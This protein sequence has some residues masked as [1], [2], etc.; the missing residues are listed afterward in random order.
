MRD[1]QELLGW[2]R[3]GRSVL[4]VWS[5]LL[6]LLAALG[7]G[8]V[9]AW[10][11]GEGP[12]YRTLFTAHSEFNGDVKVVEDAFTRF[13]MFGN[14][15][16]TGQD[17]KNLNRSAFRYV[18]GFHLG[19]A[20]VP[21][22]RSALFIGL[23]GGMG[24]RQFHDFY[25][26]MRIEAVEI[27]PLVV[28]LA[29]EYFRLPEDNRLKVFVGDGRAF[30]E[31]SKA[32]YDLIFLDAYDA[33]SAPPMLTTVEF[34]KIIRDHL[35][36]KGALVANVIAAERGAR[37]RFGRSEFKTFR[38]VFS[39]VAVFPIQSAVEENA[40]P[41]DYENLTMVAMKAGKLPDQKLWE[42]RIQRLRRPEFRE[43]TRIVRHGPLSDWPTGDV[44]V[45]T[46]ANPPH[47]ELFG[48]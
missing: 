15:L 3:K 33:H 28:R 5:V 38:S 8:R 4:A 12:R 30:L 36:P 34:M 24:P 13:L 41:T 42:Q 2:K 18:D 48:P 7:I 46:D 44:Q 39:D 25:P 35:T 21:G 40:S 26:K 17:R 22:A 6:L 29:K 23:G 19:M 43:I 16:Q 32:R 20:A 27:D 11:V 45:L 14:S 37:S 9:R 31:K 1:R 47:E 10:E